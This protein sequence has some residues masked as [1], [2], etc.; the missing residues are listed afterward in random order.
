MIKGIYDHNFT[1]C[2]IH[3]DEFHNTNSDTASTSTLISDYKNE[4]PWLPFVFSYPT[5]NVT[6]QCTPPRSNNGG[7][8]SYG[9]SRIFIDGPDNIKE[10]DES[11]KKHRERIKAQ[12]NRNLPYVCGYLATPWTLRRFRISYNRYPPSNVSYDAAAFRRHTMGGFWRTKRPAIEP[13]VGES[14]RKRVVISDKRYEDGGTGGTASAS[15][16]ESIS[17]QQIKNG[18][19]VYEGFSR[20]LA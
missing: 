2:Q 16:I 17:L 13:L 11:R 4:Q 6:T 18:V 15:M 10:K 7:K 12:Y 1:L 19:D 3:V 9:R 14:R 5:M 20:F 8:R